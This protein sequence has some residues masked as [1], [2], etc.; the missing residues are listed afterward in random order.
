MATSQKD[1][2]KHGDDSK[3]KNDDKHGDDSKKDDDKQ[4]RMTARRTMTSM[5]S[6]LKSVVV[7][8][9]SGVAAQHIGHRQNSVNSE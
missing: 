4:G 2:D 8:S 7:S 1:D 5:A 9:E 3:K 6:R